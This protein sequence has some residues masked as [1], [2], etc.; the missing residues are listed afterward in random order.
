MATL[1]AKIVL[2]VGAT[3]LLFCNKDLRVTPSLSFISQVFIC[4]TFLAG[5]LLVAFWDVAL[6]IL[7]CIFVASLMIIINI[8]HKVDTTQRDAHNTASI[9][10][11]QSD[12]DNNAQ[13]LHSVNT[14]LPTAN[15]QTSVPMAFTMA[16]R[17]YASIEGMT[18]NPVSE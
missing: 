4:L 2:A 17:S 12:Q 16:D 1:F 7:I 3:L 15:H 8:Q 9:K 13:Y 14:P 10:L 11:A 6:A 18:P 5:L